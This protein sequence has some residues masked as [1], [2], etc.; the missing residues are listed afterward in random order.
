[1]SCMLTACCAAWCSMRWCVQ[2]LLGCDA[3]QAKLVGM[4]GAKC[5]KLA[6][7]CG[8]LVRLTQLPEMSMRQLKPSTIG[9]LVAIKVC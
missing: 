4:F 7:Q 3:N 1:M 6:K 9:K 8:I 5:V 2:V